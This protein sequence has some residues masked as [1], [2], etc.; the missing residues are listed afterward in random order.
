M[1]SYT[2]Y[3]SSRTDTTIV[4]GKRKGGPRDQYAMD[5]E[6]QE[7]IIGGKDGVFITQTIDVK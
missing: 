2:G 5:N 4:A 3:E 1:K 6:S 7:R